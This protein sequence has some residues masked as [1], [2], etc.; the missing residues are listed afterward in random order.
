M[1]YN[2]IAAFAAFGA[3]SLVYAASG[4]IN[5]LTMNVGGQEVPGDKVENAKT[6]GSHLAQ[7]NYDVV[8]I[9]SDFD[10]HDSIYETDKHSH[11][12]TTL[13]GPGQG[14]GLN[15]LSNLPYTNFRRIKWNK[16]SNAEGGDCDSPKGFTFMR[17]RVSEGVYIDMYNLQTD[18]GMKGDDVSARSS[19]LGQVSDYI[20]TWS[21][22]NAV[23]VFGDTN[24]IFSR[25][26]DNINIFNEQNGMTDAWYTLVRKGDASADITCYNPSD[27]LMCELGD[28]VISRGSP[29]LKLDATAFEYVGDSFLQSDGQVLSN[30]DPVKVS[31]TWTQG[32]TLHQSDFVGEA[33]GDA[34]FN[35]AT[36][37]SAKSNRPKTATIAF[38]GGDVVTQVSLTLNDNTKFEHGVVGS[39]SKEL[40]L[41]VDEFWT[42]VDLC[43]CTES[44]SGIVYIKATTTKQGLLEVG[45]ATNNCQTHS[46]PSGFQIVGFAG[47]SGS[48]I[49]QLSVIYG[50]R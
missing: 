27:T 25:T 12:T 34:W 33:D 47:Q 36:A 43:Q 26:A 48:Q 24:S 23:M 44:G 18:A 19:N 14:D 37:L 10:N 20:K 28:K 39:Q 22:G 38:S 46:A 49:E 2:T 40:N 13:G 45:K 41:E 8:N 3:P 11:R 35:D 6:I 4:T 50:L 17:V 42:T 1:K 15:T 5:V 30:R 7:T 32:E 29:L 31:L 21:E 16:C 9:Q